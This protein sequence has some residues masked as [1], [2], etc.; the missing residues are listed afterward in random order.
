MT[1]GDRHTLVIETRGH[2]VEPIRAVHVVLDIFL[3]RPHDLDRALD[4]PRDLNGA[5]DT[6]DVQ[7]AP[8]P[9]TDEMIVD[10][11]LVQRQSSGFRCRRLG[12][13]QSLGADPDFATILAHMSC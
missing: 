10:D 11:D 6:V 4:L 8:E 13:R 5:D 3:A 12:A 2:S 7:P 9:A 1:P